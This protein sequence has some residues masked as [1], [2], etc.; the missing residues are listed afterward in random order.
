MAISLTKTRSLDAQAAGSCAITCSILRK[1]LSSNTHP[2][3]VATQMRSS[4]LMQETQ[5]SKAKKTNTP[6][7]YNPPYT[8]YLSLQYSWPSR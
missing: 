6:R 3:V 4:N 8:R 7:L 5:A 2:R 1:E